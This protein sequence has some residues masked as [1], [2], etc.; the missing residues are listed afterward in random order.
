MLKQGLSRLMDQPYG[1]G[2]PWRGCDSSCAHH[3][4]ASEVRLGAQVRRAPR[5]KSMTQDPMPLMT[6]KAQA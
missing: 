6:A 4:L 1:F 5:G 3:R 2:A